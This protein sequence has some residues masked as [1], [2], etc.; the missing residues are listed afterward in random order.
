MLTQ[1]SP[2]CSKET[3]VGVGM[4]IHSFYT[5]L[6]NSSHSYIMSLQAMLSCC[7]V[8]RYRY[9]DWWRAA[10]RRKGN[11]TCLSPLSLR[12]TRRSA[13]LVFTCICFIDTLTSIWTACVSTCV[14]MYPVR[15]VMLPVFLPRWCLCMILHRVPEVFACYMYTCCPRPTGRVF[16]C[17]VTRITTLYGPASRPA[18]SVHSYKLTCVESYVPVLQYIS[19]LW[20]FCVTTY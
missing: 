18:Y 9:T 10:W 13:I 6:R 14:S 7:F 16:W 15:D 3:E 4:Y 17:R 11:S 19:G 20:D 8:R 1:V 12:P 5:A 2:P